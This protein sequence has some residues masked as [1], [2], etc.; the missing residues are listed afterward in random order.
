MLMHKKGGVGIEWPRLFMNIFIA[1]IVIAFIFITVFVNLAEDIETEDLQQ[2]IMFKMITNTESCLAYVD[3]EGVHPGKIDINKFNEA[4]LSSCAKKAGTGYSLKLKKLNGDL[5][6][7]VVQKN[8][9]Y[10]PDKFEIC[11]I[12]EGSIV[13]GKFSRIVTYKSGA[14][15]EPALLEMEVMTKD[16]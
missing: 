14:I 13:C 1:S 5:I 9:M 7:E 8:L 10:D 2:T 12:F 16:E 11:G 15:W 3:T 6:N 4:R